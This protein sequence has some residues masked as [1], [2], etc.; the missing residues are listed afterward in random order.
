M[1]KRPYFK[2]SIS[3]RVVCPLVQRLRELF[4]KKYMNIKCGVSTIITDG[5]EMKTWIVHLSTCLVFC[6]FIISNAAAQTGTIKIFSELKETSVYL[7]EVLKGND[8]MT[9]D[10]VPAGSH[11]LKVVKDEVIIYG[12]L[13]EVKAGQTTTVLV[14]DTKEIQDK[15]LA[16]KY[17]E[18]EKYKAQKLDVLLDIKYVTETNQNTATTNR[19]NSLFWPGYYSVLGTSATRTNTQSNTVSVTHS[20]TDWFIT[21]GGTKKLSHYDFAVIVN[22][23]ARLNDYE[24]QKNYCATH[25]RKIK[26]DGT[27]IIIGSV[28]AA[29]GGAVAFIP[30]MPDFSTEGK[31]G[32]QIRFVIGASSLVVG[33]GA[34][35]AGLL[36]RSPPCVAIFRPYTLEE[37]SALAKAY[38]H[39]LKKS[40]GL[41]ENWEP[42]R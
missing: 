39:N 22:D 18:Q 40:L 28:F 16:G 11:Y 17:Q 25:P 38:D 3:Y 30:P 41:P 12:E 10:N 24:E 9:L 7:D 13:I 42:D 14:K 36:H 26:P 34:V 1:Q 21:V 8:I 23:V 6:F 4:K 35:I 32:P 2:I 27:T 37:A 33:I 20:V 19:T 31:V 29:I 5:N 15:L